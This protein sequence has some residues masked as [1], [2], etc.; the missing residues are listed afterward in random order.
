MLFL[1][2]PLGGGIP[3]GVLEM[4]PGGNLGPLTEHRPLWM[5]THE[6]VQS[7]PD[8]VPKC[9]AQTDTVPKCKAQ[10]DTNPRQGPGA[11]REPLSPYCRP[12]T[13]NQGKDLVTD[14]VSAPVLESPPHTVT[15]VKADTQVSATIE[16]VEAVSEPQDIQACKFSAIQETARPRREPSGE[17]QNSDLFVPVSI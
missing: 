10:T 8:T 17:Q 12:R 2:T 16:T 6:T 11:H 13:P 15:H 14:C 5:G 1:L 4:R 3:H 9:K 7:P